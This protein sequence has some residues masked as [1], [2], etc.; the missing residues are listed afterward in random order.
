MRS[1]RRACSPGKLI[2]RPVIA[3]DVLATILT[4][5]KHTGS[6]LQAW[7]L[8]GGLRRRLTGPR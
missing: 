5:G 8:V 7:L 3:R 4:I 2:E 6:Q 1:C